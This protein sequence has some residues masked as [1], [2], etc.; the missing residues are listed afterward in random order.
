MIEISALC[1]RYGSFTAVRSLDLVLPA[2]EL[3]GFYGREAAVHEAAV[4]WVDLLLA[5]LGPMRHELALKK[6]RVFMR[7]STPWSQLVMLAVLLVVCV[8]NVR[9]P[10]IRSRDDGVAA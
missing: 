1:K 10:V 3:V 2:G 7:D 9:S 5:F 6:L 8:A 4:V